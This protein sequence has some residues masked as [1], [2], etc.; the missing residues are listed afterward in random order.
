MI[1][2]CLLGFL[3]V[4]LLVPCRLYEFHVYAVMMQRVCILMSALHCTPS[5]GGS[6][7]DIRIPAHLLATQVHV[8]NFQRVALLRSTCRAY[9]SSC[10]TFISRVFESH[11]RWAYRILW[12]QEGTCCENHGVL[13]DK[14][15][16]GLQAVRR[17]RWKISKLMLWETTNCDWSRTGMAPWARAGI[18]ESR[19]VSRARLGTS[20]SIR[21]IEDQSVS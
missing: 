9:H 19:T 20:V 2:T 6:D 3:C 14:A 13:V 21:S 11:L 18:T 4:R 5:Y 1:F 12:A 17:N 16:P 7:A 8:S 10:L 15:M